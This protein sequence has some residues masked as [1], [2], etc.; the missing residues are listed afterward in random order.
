M[1][2]IDVN[3]L[4]AVP[5]RYKST[6]VNYMKA[7]SRWKRYQSNSPYRQYLQDYVDLLET[8]NIVPLIRF[9]TPDQLFAY[10]PA[11]INVA[12]GQADNNKYV[13]KFKDDLAAEYDSFSQWYAE[14]RTELSITDYILKTNISDSDI[15]SIRE[16]QRAQYSLVLKK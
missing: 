2:I 7:V 3:N 13:S 6:L 14:R 10:Y 15:A 16:I 9:M 11:I 5:T 1:I 12:S 8:P 4:D